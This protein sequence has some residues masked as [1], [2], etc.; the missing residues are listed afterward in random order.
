MIKGWH[1]CLIK[2]CIYDEEND[3]VVWKKVYID[4]IL[5]GENKQDAL[6]VASMVEACLQNIHAAF[7]TIKSVSVQSDNAACYQSKELTLLLALLNH[8]HCPIK[9]ST[10]IHTETQDGKC[11]I[12]AHFARAMA[13]LINY[14]KT[15]HQNQVRSI[16]TAK[17]LAKALQWRGGIQNSSHQLIRVD[18]R[19][20]KSFIDRN[21]KVIAS[22]RSKLGRMNEI[23]FDIE[24][25]ITDDGNTN[26]EEATFK[27]TCLHHSGIGDGENYTI[28]M[29]NQVVTLNKSN[30]AGDGGGDNV[31]SDEDANA[32]EIEKEDADEDVDEDA[33]EDADEDI[34]GNSTMIGGDAYTPDIQGNSI[35]IG[36]DAYTPEDQEYMELYFNDTPE[37]STSAD[38]RPAIKAP[39]MIKTGLSIR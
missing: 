19:K 2:Y 32:I 24:A 36:G 25:G 26:I 8:T 30:D 15:S 3:Q 39:K 16:M 14:M 34:Q 29:K 37:T 22:L 33:D 31:N 23:I 28:D 10:I 9:I 12:D 13:F 1:G 27:M 21:K 11:D 38:T 5:E 20:L 18:R 7:P 6:A 35:M 4:Q 17:G